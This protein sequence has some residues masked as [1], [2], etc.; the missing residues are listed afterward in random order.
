MEKF[1]KEENIPIKNDSIVGIRILYDD[2]ICDNIC[3]I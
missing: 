1:L 2:N 3:L